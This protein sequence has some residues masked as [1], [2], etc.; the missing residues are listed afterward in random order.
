MH[1]TADP[2]PPEPHFVK[3]ERIRSKAPIL[4][5]LAL[6][7]IRESRQTAAQ[8][9]LARARRVGQD[10][11]IRQHSD[12]GHGIRLE[13]IVSGDTVV[14]EAD[15]SIEDAPDPRNPRIIVRRARRTDSLHVLWRMGTIDHRQ[16]DAGERLR[17]SMERSL[18]PLPGIAQSEV[19]TSP[20]SRVVIAQG[21]LKAVRQVRHAGEAMG[22]CRTAVLWILMGGS[23]NGLAAWARCHK[24]TASELVQDG[25]DLLADHYGLPEAKAAA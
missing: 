10:N 14:R 5:A 25:L 16:I 22:R 8:E 1:P 9:A 4:L 7:A 6:E 20:F 15:I 21:Q 17:W 3:L 2:G 11:G 19:H 13:A 23:I 12:F 18:A 24:T